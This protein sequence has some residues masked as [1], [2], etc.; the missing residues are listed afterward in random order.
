MSKLIFQGIIEDISNE[1][2]SDS[3][4]EKLLEIFTKTLK[5]FAEISASKPWCDKAYY[6]DL[7]E[8]EG[9]KEFDVEQ[10]SLTIERKK[11]DEKG[12]HFSGRFEHD[13]KN[14]KVLAILEMSR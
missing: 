12:D 6:R 11:S 10:F 14:L 9:A 2:C 3:Q 4:I 5:P 13:H 1:R 7:S 8:F